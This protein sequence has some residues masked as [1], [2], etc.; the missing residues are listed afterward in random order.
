MRAVVLYGPNDF[1]PAV[2]ETP[3]IGPD[4]I[5]LKMEK[6]AICGTDIRILE[7][8]KTKDVHYPSII[9]HEFA[10]VI[11][12]VGSGVEGFASG[13]RIVAAP[14]IPCGVCRSCRT[15]RENACTHRRAIAYQ[16]DGGFA[17]YIRIP[18]EIIRN[19]NVLR[20]PDHV[21]FEEGALIEPL[22]CCINGMKNAGVGFGDVVLIAG[23]GPIGLFH[24]QLAKIAGARKVIVSEPV[25][26]RRAMAKKLG[27]DVTVDPT[28]EDLT[29]VVMEHTDG[30]G[31]DVVIMAIGVP[32]LVDQ[33]LKLC[34][35]GG[36]L[37]LF[38]GFAGDGVATL[39]VNIIHYNELR[40]TGATGLRR[41]EY[42]EAARLVFDG[43]IEVKSIATHIYKIEQFHEA[44][45]MWKS[46]AALK[47]LIEP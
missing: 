3:A 33:C 37:N 5:L 17:E 14:L 39:N 18:A 1:R 38:A 28:S 41:Q 42:F 25:E 44:Y 4:E 45:E 29:K 36:G 24:L 30:L 20:L 22:A 32:S 26:S 15:G 35:K 6:A 34:R 21:S 7:G 16:Y 12:Q 43:R 23:S 27:A 47:V 31:A 10:G 8:K 9:G 13:D 2:V 11:E 46:G 40:V 19:G